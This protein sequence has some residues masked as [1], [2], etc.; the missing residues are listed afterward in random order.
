MGVCTI[1]KRIIGVLVTAGI[2]VGCLAM[3]S[4]AKGGSYSYSIYL[5]GKYLDS[6]F[7]QC[8]VIDVKASNYEKTS[9]MVAVKYG[10]ERVTKKV[11]YDKNGS[12]KLRTDYVY[13]R[14]IRYV[15]GDCWF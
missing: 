2:L 9:A 6:Q 5:A 11:T 7:S 1:H 4:L 12:Y 8:G 15:T 3:P 13:A 10:Y 14:D